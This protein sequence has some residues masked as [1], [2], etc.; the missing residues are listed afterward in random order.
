MLYKQCCTTKI[1]RYPDPPPATFMTAL[2]RY[3]PSPPQIHQQVLGVVIIRTVMQ[4]DMILFKDLFFITKSRRSIGHNE[5]GLLVYT[6]ELRNVHFHFN[7]DCIRM[8]FQNFITCYSPLCP[9]YSIMNNA[10]VFSGPKIL[11]KL[12][13]EA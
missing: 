12:D 11:S 5:N 1:P 10:N 2:V 9:H 13:I 4:M 6:D 7:E 3:C 8:V